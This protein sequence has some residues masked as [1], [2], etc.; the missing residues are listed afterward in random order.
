L[1]LTS[2]IRGDLKGAIQIIYLLYDYGYSVIDILEYFFEF[3]K[4][5][6]LIGEEAKYKVVPHICEFISVFHN[7]HENGIELAIFTNT[8]IGCFHSSNKATKPVSHEK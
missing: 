3:I 6:D 4:T 2:L 1:Y 7:I 5:T 8:I